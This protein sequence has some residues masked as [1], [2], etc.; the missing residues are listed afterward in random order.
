MGLPIASRL[1]REGTRGK[2]GLKVICQGSTDQLAHRYFG[3]GLRAGQIDRAIPIK[4]KIRFVNLAEIRD[5]TG[6]TMGE[7]RWHTRL[8]QAEP[9][10]RSGFGFGRQI[11]G[12][13]P[14]ECFLHR[15]NARVLTG[16]IKDQISKGEQCRLCRIREGGKGGSHVQRCEIARGHGASIVTTPERCNAD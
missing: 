1:A 9:D 3:E 5:H 10:R 8:G 14:P 13:A 6:L 4:L 16:H 2:G 15:S 12:L 11:G 7:N